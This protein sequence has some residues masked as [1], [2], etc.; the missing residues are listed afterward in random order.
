MHR[1]FSCFIALPR[2]VQVIVA[3]EG[4]ASSSVRRC[5]VLSVALPRV[6]NR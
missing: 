2:G 4:R 3:L 1:P 5:V 6:V